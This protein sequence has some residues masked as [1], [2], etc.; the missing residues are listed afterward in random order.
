M[1]SVGDLLVSTGRLNGYSI[2]AIAKM[3]SSA[4]AN[5][6]A[7][8]TQAAQA[9]AAAEAAHQYARTL[10]NWFARHTHE[11]HGSVTGGG[12]CWGSTEEPN[13]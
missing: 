7:A 3:A 6:I 9:Q 4:N 5:A 2:A 8:S 1:A 10:S 13:G 12:T 11:F